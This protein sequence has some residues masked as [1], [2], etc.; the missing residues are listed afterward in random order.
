MPPEDRPEIP[1]KELSYQI[2]GAAMLAYNELGTGFY[3]AVYRRATA[4]ALRERGIKSE[5][6]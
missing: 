6:E 1:F 2:V 3:E 5:Q 4:I